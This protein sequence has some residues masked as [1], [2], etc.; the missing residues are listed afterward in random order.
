MEMRECKGEEMGWMKEVGDEKV[1]R[2]ERRGWEE[3]EEEEVEV[4]GVLVV[5]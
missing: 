5:P 2:S 1:S 4:E 3:E